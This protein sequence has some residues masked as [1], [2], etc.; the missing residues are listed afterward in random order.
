MGMLSVDRHAPR[1]NHLMGHLRGA[2][3]AAIALASVTFGSSSMAAEQCAETDFDAFLARFS[4]DAEFQRR[5]VQFPLP[6]QANEDKGI[7]GPEL[8]ETQVQS[9]PATGALYLNAEQ[10]KAHKLEV[11]V[12]PTERGKRVKLEKPDTDYLIY[13]FFEQR[14]CWTLVRIENYSL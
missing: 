1:L 4:E 9:W 11:T 2:A 10:R 13:Y 5:H 12:S 7:R 8:V 6:K 14:P 3:V